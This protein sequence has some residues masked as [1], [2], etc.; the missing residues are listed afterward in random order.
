M[1]LGNSSGQTGSR[2][3]GHLVK[4]IKEVTNAIDYHALSGSTVESGHADA[5]ALG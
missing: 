2:R 5:C 4:R 1:G 3:K